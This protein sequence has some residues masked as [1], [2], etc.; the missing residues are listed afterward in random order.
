MGVRILDSCKNLFTIQWRGKHPVEQNDSVVL[1]NSSQVCQGI[2]TVVILDYRKLGNY[3]QVASE[4]PSR[5][6]VINRTYS[7]LLS[8]N[9]ATTW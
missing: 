4:L 9:R 5:L 2:L 7:R 1:L 8:G 3:S 6:I